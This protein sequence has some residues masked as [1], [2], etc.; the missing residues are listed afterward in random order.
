MII[1][2]FIVTPD[3]TNVKCWYF[4]ASEDDP[5]A[6]AQVQ[7]KWIARDVVAVQKDQAEDLDDEQTD[8]EKQQG[9]TP[10]RCFFFY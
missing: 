2:F 7:Y 4:Q 6:P 9:R 8:A 1:L 10:V 3:N 5:E